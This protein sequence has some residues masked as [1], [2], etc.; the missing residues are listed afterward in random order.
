MLRTLT[1]LALLAGLVSAQSSNRNKKAS[2]QLLADAIYLQTHPPPGKTE[3][4]A[5]DLAYLKMAEAIEKDRYNWR[6][7]FHRGFNR[8]LKASMN[9]GTLIQTLHEMR[10]QGSS[11]AEQARIE[12]FGLQFIERTLEEIR[13]NFGAMV[14]AM[15]Q[16]REG[17]RDMVDFS[18]AATKF[19][20]G[21]Y[22][23]ARGDTAGAIDEL[24]Q[25][26]QRR[27][28]VEL[29][30]DLIARSYMQLGAAAF[31]AE[32]YTLAQEFWDKGL[33]W[34][35]SKSIRR[36]L[37]TNKAGAYEMDNEFGLA[38]RLLRQQI[39]AEPERPVHWKNM[40]LVLGYQNHLRTALYAYDRAREL[41]TTDGGPNAMA[42]LHGN[43]WLKAAMIH[44]KL[45]ES[46]GDLRQAWRLFLQYRAMFGDDYNF[47]FNFGEFCYHMGEYDLAWTF[48]SRAAE[49]H[50][51]CPTPYLLLVPVAQRMTSGTPEE[52]K[53]RRTQAKARLKKVREAYNSR[54]ESQQLKRIC[55]GLRDLG[56]G[57]L[58]SEGA[59]RLDPDPLKGLSPDAPPAWLLAMAAKREPFTVFNP[60]VEEFLSESAS[61]TEVAAEELAEH[62]ADVS[63]VEAYIVPGG[64]LWVL[65]AALLL[66]IGLGLWLRRR[67]A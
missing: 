33:K 54:V 66:I 9:R 23:R 55:G 36:T 62:A 50:P 57:G 13:Q 56:D 3:E 42:L 34:A 5:L 47:S 38:E 49:I 22:L 17:D 14:H 18:R 61:E 6:A 32:R 65:G 1:I 44:G 21:E 15:K 48:L 16:T 30:A 40:G 63:W 4:D 27:W 51:F 26:V 53:E 37:L 10:A 12:G 60:S 19:A 29:C 58:R 7:F 67:S 8:C 28:H 35:R 64:T 20:T 41:C 45:L 52:R 2:A 31:G 24:K 11:P 25:L 43:A 59:P 39:K 46:N